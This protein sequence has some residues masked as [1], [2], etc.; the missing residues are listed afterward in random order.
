MGGGPN[1]L[2]PKVERGGTAELQRMGIAMGVARQRRVL[3][4]VLVLGL[5]V[6]C[7]TSRHGK[8]AARMMHD[9]RQP[10]ALRCGRAEGAG[11]HACGGY[12]VGGRGGFALS[13]AGEQE[14]VD[15]SMLHPRF[16]WGPGPMRLKGGHGH[17][18]EHIADK[19][20]KKRKKALD[21]ELGIDQKTQDAEGEIA[22]E[23]RG[24]PLRDR[25]AIGLEGKDLD[26]V[27]EARER[28]MDG[29]VVPHG[30]EYAKREKSLGEQSSG[31]LAPGE[32]TAGG[33]LI[34]KRGLDQQDVSDDSADE[35]EE[36]GWNKDGQL[37]YHSKG[38]NVSEALAMGPSPCD[39][40]ARGGLLHMRPRAITDIDRMP[41]CAAQFWATGGAGRPAEAANSALHRGCVGGHIF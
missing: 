26:E 4:G 11:G 24:L 15:G 23:V 18:K 3:V 17:R 38:G 21:K 33:T 30:E 22:E 37:E 31:N 13:A 6:H 19:I 25:L 41:M 10:D 29:L 5:F 39:Q 14:Q 32:G 27:R 20:Y 1:S 35:G 28:T 16:G 36:Q 12:L 34:V 2:G 40:R 7:D 8:G 9:A